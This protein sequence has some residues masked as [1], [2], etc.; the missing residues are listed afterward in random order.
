MTSAKTAFKTIPV[1]GRGLHAGYRSHIIQ[2]D[3]GTVA[4]IDR[5]QRG[6]HTIHWVQIDCPIDAE[7][8]TGIIH[9]PDGATVDCVRAADWVAYQGSEGR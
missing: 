8:A 9:L 2:T 4:T 3:N 1:E 6:G 7:P 5:D